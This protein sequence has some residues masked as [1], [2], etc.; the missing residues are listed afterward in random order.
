MKKIYLVLVISITS[1]AILGYTRYRIS[2]TETGAPPYV[3]EDL[4]P[5]E[6][7][8]PYAWIK[9]WTR[10][11]G[12]PRVG[13][14][15]GHWKNEE[16]PE[17]LSRLVGS[18]GTSGGGKSEWE[19]NKSVAEETKKILESMGILVDILPAT[20]PPQYSAD[21]FIA[22]HADGNVDSSVS[23]FKVAAPRRDF[24]Q[25]ADAFVSLLEK[26]YGEATGL[27]RDPNISRN[28]RGYYAFAWW[29]YTH[30]V[31]PMTPA[32]ILE[33]GFLTNPDDQKVIVKNPEKSAQGIADAVVVF[34]RNQ[35]LLKEG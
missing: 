14:Q 7:L 30:A 8:D 17:E 28:M 11:D 13:L 1:L 4:N 18:T 33:T 34:L 2:N 31:H 25:K 10:D 6:N 27:S 21:I 9:N 32:V 26:S 16:L 15:V 20:I 5:P 24:T 29:R 35:N 19:V 3:A 22:I 12:P 23:G